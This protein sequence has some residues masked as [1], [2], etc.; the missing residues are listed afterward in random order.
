MTFS[1]KSIPKITALYW[2]TI[3]LLVIVNFATTFIGFH[4]HH[5]GL[6]FTTIRLLKANLLN[7]GEYPFNQRLSVI[8]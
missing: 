3:T 5:D 8:L 1:L 2:G 4:P 6:V 7:G